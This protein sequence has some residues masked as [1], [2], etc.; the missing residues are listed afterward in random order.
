MLCVCVCAW[1]VCAWCDC[2]LCVCF[3]CVCFE[4]VCLRVLPGVWYASPTHLSLQLPDGVVL[5]GGCDFECGNSGK[6]F[7]VLAPLQ[8][9][10]LL[11]PLK[12][13]A[14]LHEILSRRCCGGWRVRW[15]DEGEKRSEVVQGECVC[16]G[17]ACVLSV[18][19]LCVRLCR[20]RLL[21]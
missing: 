6:V 5:L 4:C 20:V 19:L 13:V 2:A 3:V 9:Q 21:G 15:A 7:L 14:R 8:L 16:L 10:A 11:Q 18:C 12:V 17:S 1:C